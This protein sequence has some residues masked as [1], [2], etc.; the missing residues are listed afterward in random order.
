MVYF[1]NVLTVGR[2]ALFVNGPRVRPKKGLVNEINAAGDVTLIVY[3]AGG[4]KLALP[5]KQSLSWKGDLHPMAKIIPMTEHFQH[6]PAEMKESFWGR[7]VWADEAGVAAFFR[8]A[9]GGATSSLFGLRA[10]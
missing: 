3:E 6:F 8:A 4:R 10:P 1:G 2:A 7:S 5:D 9:L